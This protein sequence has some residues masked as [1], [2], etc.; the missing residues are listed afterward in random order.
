MKKKICFILKGIDRKPS[1]TTVTFHEDKT[2]RNKNIYIYIYSQI[3]VIFLVT[4]NKNFQKTICG[5]FP[6][7]EFLFKL[8]IH[9]VESSSAVRQTKTSVCKC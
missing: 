6:P 5:R 3:S 1:C 4:L 9:Q 7:Q 8:L 2:Q